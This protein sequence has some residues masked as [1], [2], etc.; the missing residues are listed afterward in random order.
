MKEDE[1]K[2]ESGG[3]KSGGGEKH[4]GRVNSNIDST[5][6]L[7]ASKRDELSNELRGGG[8]R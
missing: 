1:L 5:A 7:V 2:I 3:G 8:G 6:S 4:A